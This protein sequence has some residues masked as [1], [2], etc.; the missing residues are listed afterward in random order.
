M[1]NAYHFVLDL[2]TLATGPRAVVRSLALHRFAPWGEG[3]GGVG[4]VGAPRPDVDVARLAAIGLD[5]IGASHTWVFDIEDQARRGRTMDTSTVLW[6][7]GQ[8]A[9]AREAFVGEGTHV[10]NTGDALRTI[11]DV[12]AGLSRPV[13]LWA[14]PIHFDLPILTSLADDYGLWKA[15]DSLLHRRRVHNA[16]TI[17]EAAGIV[18]DLV[19]DEEKERL[20]AAAHTPAADAR[21]TAETITRSLQ[22]LDEARH[23]LRRSDPAPRPSPSPGPG[24]GHDSARPDPTPGGSGGAEAE[25]GARSD[26]EV[27]PGRLPVA[28]R[29]RAAIAA[30]LPSTAHADLQ[31]GERLN[32]AITEGVEDWRIANS[33]RSIA[34][35]WR[36]LRDELLAFDAVC[37]SR[38]LGDW[39]GGPS[40][41]R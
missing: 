21:L 27:R 19:V 41:E 38:P 1:R 2:E 29:A 24:S 25:A 6:W 35:V 37:A 36:R 4:E 9:V 22:I 8:S 32:A 23:A 10:W 11:L 34:A 14:K 39:P 18:A 7:I 16:R 5:R 13:Y 15:A 40:G 17:Y 3:E 33:A 20:G 28:G 30:I 26:A 31:A 12:L